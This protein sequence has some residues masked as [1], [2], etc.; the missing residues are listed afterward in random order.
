MH[1]H[2]GKCGTEMY[3]GIAE[4]D[5]AVML[6]INSKRI[7]V[8]DVEKYALLKL[9]DVDLSKVQHNQVVD[10]NSNGDRWEGDVLNGV[11]CGVGTQYD[12]NNNVAFEGFRDGDT[13][14][15]YGRFFYPDIHK[16]EYEGEMCD[17]K[18]WGRGTQFDR[19]GNVL[20]DGEWVN[21]VHY[22]DRCVTVN[23]DNE[24]KVVLNGLI[25]ELVIEDGSGRGS[26]WRYLDLRLMSCLRTLRIGD[27]C[28][29]R[30]DGFMATGMKC[31]E[32]VHIGKN[33]FT[34]PG[35]REIRATDRSFFLED[36][37]NVKELKIG[38]HSFC[39]YNF[40]QL[41]VLPALEVLE[42]GDML[43]NERHGCFTQAAVELES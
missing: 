38:Y 9:N 40:C 36:C 18:R 20:F 34:L 22:T 41:H 19:N 16:I 28:Y 37:P 5:D 12:K 39:D 24:C 3:D 6:E 14:C 15:C 13:I 35:Y 8:V 42:I 31:L 4:Y 7:M 10:L 11:P 43:E 2:E 1:F 23:E 33:S 27:N 17:G 25:E 26:Q 29:P 21:D 32:T 30:V